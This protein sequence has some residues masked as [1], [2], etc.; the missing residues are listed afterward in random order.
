MTVKVLDVIVPI[1]A[2][3]HF[4]DCFSDYCTHIPSLPD[5]FQRNIGFR[6]AAAGGFGAVM[7]GAKRG[8]FNSTGSGLYLVS[9]AQC[10]RPGKLDSTGFRCIYS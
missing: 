10:E 4:D 7:N 3:F 2:V 8:L 5:N 1:M 9:A 6:Q